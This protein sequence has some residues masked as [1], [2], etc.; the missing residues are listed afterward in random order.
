MRG[1]EG[2]GGISRPNL[3]RERGLKFDQVVVET[4][5]DPDGKN[6]SK[7]EG[8]WRLCMCDQEAFPSHVVTLGRPCSIL[9]QCMWE[10]YSA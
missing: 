7:E 1:W 9:C 4:L 10:D 2:L 3:G 6:S 8:W 5:M